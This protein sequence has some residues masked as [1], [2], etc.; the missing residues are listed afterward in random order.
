[1]RVVYDP[2]SE[3]YDQHF[4]N[5]I[6][7]SAFYQGV[8]FRRGVQT[9]A[10]FGAI[11][12]G[13]SRYLIPL[14]STIGKEAGRQGLLMGSKVMDSFAQGTPINM[15]QE[16]KSSV[17]SLKNIAHKALQQTGEGRKRRRKSVQSLIGKR[18]RP[19]AIPAPPKDPFHN[20]ERD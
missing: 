13:F 10:G 15:Q 3:Q 8:P 6:G 14:V 18:L 4:Q 11:L 12:A 5:Q 16:L 2:N 1:M 7:G 9:G 19:Q 17:H 20:N